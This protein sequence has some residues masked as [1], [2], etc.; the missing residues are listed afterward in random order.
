MGPI[1][2]GEMSGGGAPAREAPF[3]VRKRG[4]ILPSGTGAGSSRENGRKGDGFPVFRGGRLF[5][6]PLRVGEGATVRM[7]FQG[8]SMGG[9]MGGDKG[10]WVPAGSR[11]APTGGKGTLRMTFNT[12]HRGKGDGFPPSCS[13]GQALRGKNGGGCGITKGAWGNRA[14]TRVAPTE[15]AKVGARMK[16]G[17]PPPSSRGQALR[18]KN[19][20]RKRVSGWRPPSSRGQALRGGMPG[21]EGRPYGDG[22]KW[23]LG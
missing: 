19:G 6:R 7:I 14:T 15:M 16:D 18:G 4:W 13:W 8:R 23:V 9:R 17:F 10:K 1:G 3:G 21:G 22:G 20:W 5:E 2:N 12:L 11:T